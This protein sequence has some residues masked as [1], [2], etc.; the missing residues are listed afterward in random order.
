[1]PTSG[2]GPAGGEPSPDVWLAETRADHAARERARASS[3]QRQAAEEAT[4]AAVLVD[5]AERGEPVS[6]H[7]RS[8]R[9]VQGAILWVGDDGVVVHTAAH[10]LTLVA[11]AA[12]TV[13]SAAGRSGAPTPRRRPAGADRHALLAGIA[14][15]GVRVQVPVGPGGTT[16]G[17]LEHVGAD[18]LAVR[19]DDRSLAHLPLLALDEVT[20]LDDPWGCLGRT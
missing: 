18:V 12:L 4:V 14:G 3:L 2:P 1:M 17:E 6:L 16:V 20:L 5:L 19:R 7:L 8:G 9:T 11:T 13:V 10:R 15:D